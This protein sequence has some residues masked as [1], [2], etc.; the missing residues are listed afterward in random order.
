MMNGKLIYLFV[1]FLLFNFGCSKTIKPKQWIT[2]KNQVTL[3]W[4]YD[5]PSDILGFEIE[6]R[7]DLDEHFKK[8]AIVGPNE[9]SYTDTGLIPGTTY[10]YR[11][12]AYDANF[13][14][15]YTE[16]KVIILDNSTA[17]KK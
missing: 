3:S 12:R 15:E 9:T 7:K 2:T 14:S 13:K 11:T 17:I 10:Y 5:L 1:F 8:I 6:R 16:I 4:E